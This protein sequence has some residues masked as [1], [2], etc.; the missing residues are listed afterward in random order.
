MEYGLNTILK[1]HMACKNDDHLIGSCEAVSMSVP[2]GTRQ[3]WS[4]SMQSAMSIEGFVPLMSILSIVGTARSQHMA[5]LGECLLDACRQLSGRYR[6]LIN[7]DMRLLLSRVKGI[8]TISGQTNLLV[9][10]AKARKTRNNRDNFKR[11]IN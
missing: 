6:F 1:H 9:N 7:D 2:T 11:V 4:D 5:E 10:R 8:N 3:S